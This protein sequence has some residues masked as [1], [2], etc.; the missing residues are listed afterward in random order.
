MFS[1]IFQ[2]KSLANRK[3]IPE[4]VLKAKTIEPLM[5]LDVLV[6]KPDISRD[7][8]L[9]SAPTTESAAMK[10]K[11][12]VS[13][14]LRE[15][16]DFLK[17]ATKAELK[18]EALKRGKNGNPSAIMIQ[19]ILTVIGCVI[20]LYK[21]SRMP[22]CEFEINDL[23]ICRKT[24]MGESETPWAQVTKVARTKVGYLVFRKS[25]AMPIPFRCMELNELNYFDQLVKRRFDLY[26]IKT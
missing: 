15:Y 11:F 26:S 5:P 13:Y 19:F 4:L 9:K 25:G 24:K 22:V 21:R 2:P 6:A 18:K 7:S 10:I 16:L 23:G 8:V 20:Y 14:T 1:P 17:F 3:H 12:K